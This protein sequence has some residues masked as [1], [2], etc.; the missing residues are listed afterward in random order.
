MDD[1]N[2]E[3]WDTIFPSIHHN[4]GY[5]SAMDVVFSMD[6]ML[7]CSMQGLYAFLFSAFISKKY[8]SVTNSVK[9]FWIF[10]LPVLT[11]LGLQAVFMSSPETT[12]TVMAVTK[13]LHVLPALLEVGAVMLGKIIMLRYKLYTYYLTCKYVI[14]NFGIQAF[15]EDQWMRLEIPKVL[16]VFW[17]IRFSW[18]LIDVAFGTKGPNNI[19]IDSSNFWNVT[20]QLSTSSCDSSLAVLGLSAVVA[21]VT[22]QIGVL[23]DKFLGGNSDE[24]A[25]IGPVSAVLF[26]ILALQTGL[27]GLEPSKRFI[28]LYRNCILLTTALLHFFHGMVNQVMMTLSTAPSMAVSR[29]IRALIMCAIL[30]VF[31]FSLVLYLWSTAPMGT[32]LFAVTA[33]CMELVVKV[34]ITFIIYVL[35]LIDTHS[36]TFWEDLD[37]YVYY[38]KAVGSTVEFV[39]GI[40]LLGNGLWILFMESGG[41]IRG[42]MIGIH[43]YFNIFQ[44][45]KDGWK[46]FKNRRLAVKKINSLPEA[47]SAQLSLHNDVCAICYEE[48]V[49]ARITPCGHLFHAL[50]LRKWLYVQDSC[51]LCHKEIMQKPG[52][53]TQEGTGEGVREDE[54]DEMAAHI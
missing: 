2:I 52:D 31:P 43:A 29:H 49:T 54:L 21:T 32:W 48:L 39:V 16:R 3:H 27:A 6:F 14:T 7:Y 4:E 11:K 25:N 15:I 23:T 42:V 9:Y 30:V 24:V 37:D 35:F 20:T 1:A 34:I 10:M 41:I 33:F 46:K 44:L 28:R 8:V 22:H 45:G 19:S 5:L 17:L 13:Y 53:E 18:Q 50:C 47:N 51:P 40:F 12:E 38:I 36:E 26:F